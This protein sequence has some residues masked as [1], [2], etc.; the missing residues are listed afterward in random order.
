[1]YQL[2]Q[3]GRFIRVSVAAGDEGQSALAA[4]LSRHES[5]EQ[6]QSPDAEGEAK[7]CQYAWQLAGDSYAFLR[8]ITWS[9]PLLG[10]LGTV[11]GIS[12]T[13]QKLGAGMGGQA[14]S[15]DLLVR[16]QGLMLPLG[17]AFDTTL[18]SLSLSIVLG[19]FQALVQ[20]TETRLLHDFEFRWH[21]IAE[22]H[23]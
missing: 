6:N 16:L 22:R 9:I 2:I 14:D 19:L 15:G 8:Y 17:V 11:V 7:L 20:R 18:I 23:D 1:M 5:H 12:E 10:F 3:E 13:V 4:I 21:S